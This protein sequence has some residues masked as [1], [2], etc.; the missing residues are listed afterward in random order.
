MTTASAKRYI[1]FATQ[2]AKGTPATT[3]S[4]FIPHVA[5]QS[6][7]KWNANKQDEKYQT[8]DLFVL[9]DGIPVKPMAS[10]VIVCPFKP[11]ALNSLLANCC[12]VNGD[13]APPV[14]STFFIGDGINEK[15]Y[16]DVL[17]SQAKMAVVD[18]GN[19]AMWTLNFLGLNVP[20][21]GT[22]HTPT[23]PTYERSY[24]MADLQPFTFMG[25]TPVNGM[26]SM[27]WTLDAGST[28]YYG[29]KGDG[30]D[31][32]SDIIVNE[33]NATVD[34]VMSYISDA[35]RLAYIN[36][37]GNFGVYTFEFKSTC[38]TAHS[39]IFSLPNGSIY[40]DEEN[41]P[42]NL[43]INEAFTVKGIRQTSGTGAPATV[44]IDTDI[45]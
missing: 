22:V 1:G 23:L 29:S 33:L 2:T 44:A 7:F 4:L 17:C 43:V 41:A 24:R 30:T 10:G 45:A 14:Y 34:G 9:V 26:E 12:Y 37:C 3:P 19:P 38:G 31:G 35:Y 18:D 6:K 13:I 21:V 27:N 40:D 5:S 11:S 16:S 36:A 28:A 25:V 39:H 15:V 20:T 8:G 42:D 32:P